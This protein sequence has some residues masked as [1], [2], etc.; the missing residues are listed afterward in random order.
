MGFITLTNG[1]VVHTSAFDRNPV[2]SIKIIRKW[3]KDNTTYYR[4]LMTHKDGST[5]TVTRTETYSNQG[6]FSYQI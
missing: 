5:M 1:E 4:Q 2:V 3:R 6:P